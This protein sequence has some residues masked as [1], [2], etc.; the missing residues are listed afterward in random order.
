M[1]RSWSSFEQ[2]I[3]GGGESGGKDSWRRFCI[4]TCAP[5]LQIIVAEWTEKIGPLEYSIDR[6]RV[7]DST[8]I[9]RAVGSQRN[10]S[11]KASAGGR[12]D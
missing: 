10:G 7:A 11:W 5:I 8:A 1:Q 3:V 4:S 2:L 9:A 6:L 12:S